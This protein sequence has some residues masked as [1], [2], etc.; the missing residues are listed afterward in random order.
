M[1]SRLTALSLVFA[2]VATST[3]TW[4]THSVGSERAQ[5]RAMPLVQLEPVVIHVQR[6]PTTPR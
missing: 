4:A 3:I 1:I 2:V 5:Q 6:G